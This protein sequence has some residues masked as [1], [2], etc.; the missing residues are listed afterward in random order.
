MKKDSFWV[1]K[2]NSDEYFGTWYENK[3]GN[4]NKAHTRG[5]GYAEGW[6]SEKE[7]RLKFDSKSSA[8]DFIDAMDMFPEEPEAR[9]VKVNVISRSHDESEDRDPPTIGT[10]YYFHSN[11]SVAYVITKIRADGEIL[12]VSAGN[13]APMIYGSIDEWHDEVDDGTIVVIHDPKDFA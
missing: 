12:R 10:V 13:L 7:F 1:V 8:Q 6:C 3:S 2:N 9:V 11:P 4:K 5:S